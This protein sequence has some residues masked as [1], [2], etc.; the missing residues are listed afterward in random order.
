M[1][2]GFNGKNQEVK[3]DRFKSWI[4]LF[5]I[6]HPSSWN[7][8]SAPFLR[9]L[10]YYDG[11]CMHC[12]MPD[13]M[14]FRNEWTCLIENLENLIIHIEIIDD[15]FRDVLCCLDNALVD[16]GFS[17]EDTKCQIYH[18]LFAVFFW[19]FLYFLISFAKLFDYRYK[20]KFQIPSYFSLVIRR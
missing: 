14:A 6:M 4:Y 12:C 17:Y 13:Y 1:P 7:P 15:N 18:L 16:I 19:F 11:S 2:N 10:K 9:T 5:V 3:P 20:F 8:G